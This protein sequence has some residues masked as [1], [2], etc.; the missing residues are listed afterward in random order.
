MRGLD[1]QVAR[2]HPP[3]PLLT[4]GGLRNAQPCHEFLLFADFSNID[5]AADK[6][7]RA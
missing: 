2:S 4:G 7:E 1:S 6:P 5:A 3:S